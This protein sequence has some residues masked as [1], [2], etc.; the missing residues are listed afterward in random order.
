MDNSLNQ[1]KG[2]LSSR[3]REI[4]SL[5]RQLGS[6]QEELSG[7]GREREIVMRENRRLQ[8]DLATMTREN[9]VVHT[10]MEEALHEKDE[11]SLLYLRS[12]K[13]RE[14][15]DCKG[16]RRSILLYLIMPEQENGEM[17]EQSEDRELK[18]QHA[19]GLN[20]SIRL[21]LLSSDT[22]RRHLME[23]HMSALQ[24]YEVQ[25]SSL[26]R[27]MSRL[28]EALQ[29][30]RGEKTVLL[31]DLASVRE[32][33]VKLDSSKDLSTHQFTSKSMELERVTEEL[34]DVRCEAE[35]LKKQ[36][37]SE[38]LNVRNLE[39]L[40][41][42]NRQK[43]FH[44]HLSARRGPCRRCADKVSFSF[45]RSASPPSRSESPP[46]LTR[47]FHPANSR[48]LHRQVTRDKCEL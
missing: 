18:L 47:T 36:L 41:S 25:V 17:L 3:E 12:G 15:D 5:R 37:A 34:E 7:V 9:Q 1:L 2:A 24:V 43:E 30:A 28:E 19:E 22:E 48:A 32:L 35:L 14:Y 46:L 39:T 42:S 27:G 38:R 10:E 4:A 16:K 11:S 29:E 21:E 33:C 8:D 26:A 45:L 6:S 23:T 13:D 40:L 20:N 44:T 31:S